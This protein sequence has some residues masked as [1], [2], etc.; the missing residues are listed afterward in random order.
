ML[1][2]LLRLPLFRRLAWQGAA[3]YTFLLAVTL[4]IFG[5][6]GYTLSAQT[7]ESELGKRLVMAANFT[8]RSLGAS[9]LGP[10]SL[11]EGPARRLSRQLREE[12]EAAHLDRLLL[13]SP[14]G[15]VLLD[16]QGLAK[17]GT[18]YVYLAL[19]TA[20]WR[21]ALEGA[22]QATTL[23]PGSDGRLYKSAFAPI[24]WGGRTLAVVRAEASA[25]FLEDLRRLGRS[26]ALV[27]LLSLALGLALSL[28]A[29]RPLYR[30]LQQLIVA[31]KEVA[32][33]DFSA[34]VQLKRPDELG[35]LA[36]TFNEMAAEL[37]TYVLQRERLA[38]LGQVA[39]G[40]AH[41]IRNP[42]GAIAALAELLE[43]RLKKGDK[44]REHARDI[45]REVRE[46][47]GFIE[48][49]LEYARPRAQKREDCDL[50]AVAREALQVAFPKGGRGRGRF[51]AGLAGVKSLPASTDPRQLRQVLLNLLS[52]ARE[53]SPKGGVVS[54]EV[55]RLGAEAWLA[56]SDQGRGIPAAD[57]E[58][59]FQP[60]F[61]SKPMGT[62]LGLPIA[63][64]MVE[65]LGG[66][67]E[68]ESREGKGSRFTVI[69][70]LDV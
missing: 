35:Q 10:G 59:L 14:E 36:D 70:P 61:T 13:L 57:R 67:I 64:K 63:L 9:A 28:V 18:P 49:F 1:D 16:S 11:A 54:L 38:A 56:V 5:F 53:A 12:A 52:N 55:L 47:N 50:V 39:A 69:L 62:G 19:D 20:Q 6:L 60:F 26:M 30:P 34:R 4:A 23:F 25:D 3:F 31:S 22:A 2:F 32:K 48:D 43:G 27:G 33:G 68:V 46:V 24:Q 45:V 37:G 41:E 66:R 7:L 40:M 21:G 58:R 42:L 15:Q 44:A 17:A 51:R 29:A 65:G 8:A